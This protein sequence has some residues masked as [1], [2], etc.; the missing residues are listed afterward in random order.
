MDADRFVYVP[1]VT[2]VFSQRILGW[3]VSGELQVDFGRMGLVYDSDAE[4]NR[5]A[6][7]LIFTACYSR[8]CFVWLTFTQT[9]ASVIDGFEAA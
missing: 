9:L 4:R 1:F 6:H 8:Y 5:V 7:A 2:D 3:K